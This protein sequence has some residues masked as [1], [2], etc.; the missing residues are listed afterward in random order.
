MPHPL[1]A[2]A[3]M[4]E[5]PPPGLTE[6]M[7]ERLIRAFYTRVRAN[8]SLGPIF[9]ARLGSHWEEHI[10]KLTDFW[11]HIGLRTGRYAGRPLPAHAALRLKPEHF[12]IWLALFDETA[13][14]T[15]PPDAARFF[16]ARACRI[17]ESFQLGLDIGENA[18][19]FRAA[20]GE[21][22]IN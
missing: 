21:R 11:S 22:E 9:Q 2:R 10:S 12:R 20:Q 6:D 17:A 5:E 14:E 15:L 18:L 3:Q 8:A 19:A 16:I 4:F 13:R 7:I 1:A